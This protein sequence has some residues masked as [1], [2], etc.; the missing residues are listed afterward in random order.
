MWAGRSPR[1]KSRTDVSFTYEGSGETSRRH[2]LISRSQLRRKTHKHDW[3]P[4]ETESLLENQQ[5]RRLDEAYGLAVS[6]TGEYSEHRDHGPTRI[7]TTPDSRAVQSARAA[8]SP[9]QHHL[10]RSALHLGG[11]AHHH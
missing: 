3:R 7:P 4:E 6:Q 11:S 9:H 2:A 10:P 8:L 5:P 1:R